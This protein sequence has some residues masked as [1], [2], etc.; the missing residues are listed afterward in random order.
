MP[1]FAVG[2]CTAVWLDQP[3]SVFLMPKKASK[4]TRNGQ[5]GCATG[6][7][8]DGF[9]VQGSGG[10]LGS[11]VDVALQLAEICRSSVVGSQHIAL[12]ACDNFLHGFKGAPTARQP[13]GPMAG[14]GAAAQA[15]RGDARL[16]HRAPT[17]P[18]RVEQKATADC[19]RRPAAPCRAEALRARRR[20]P[21]SSP[22]TRWPVAQ[23][24]TLPGDRAYLSDR[25]VLLAPGILSPRKD[26]RQGRPRC[27][28]GADLPRQDL[29]TCNE[30]WGPQRTRGSA[31]QRPIWSSAG[32]R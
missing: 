6:S 13:S 16:A 24:V 18:K 1:N 19:G 29:G 23:A 30:T 14:S 28:A 20:T 27:A 31:A 12:V 21:V 9:G 22:G 32:C 11:L 17:R 2:R 8:I 15:I 10:L 25:A 3:L 7:V 4:A 5:C 26:H